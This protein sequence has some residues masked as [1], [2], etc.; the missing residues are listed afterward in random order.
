[1]TGRRAIAGVVTALGLAAVVACDAP[2]E[3]RPSADYD[4][5]ALTG[6]VAYRWTNGARLRI[7]IQPDESPGSVDLPLAVRHAI[8][9]WGAVPRFGEFTLATTRDPL[10]ADI[11]V[12]DRATP[13]PVVA[14]S[15][16]LRIGNAA[17]FAWFCRDPL[18]STRAERFRL[19]AGAVTR[20]SVLIR[21][22]KGRVTSQAGYNALVAHEL[23]H[24]LGIGGHSPR[25][26]DLMYASPLVDTPSPRDAAT[27]RAVLGRRPSLRL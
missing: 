3:A 27:L 14:P 16:P 1:M 9:V 6:G 7:W 8:A 17:G 22:D 5:T 25:A 23:G 2:T 13:E 24:A 12:Y 21:V 4:P 20:A 15:C 10:D 18:D 11:L 26:D 19:T